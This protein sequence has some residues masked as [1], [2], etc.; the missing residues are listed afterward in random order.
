MEKRCKCADG[1]FD[2][3]PYPE[4]LKIVK[5]RGFKDESPTERIDCPHQIWIGSG[6]IPAYKFTRAEWETYQ[7]ESTLCLYKK[8][9][10]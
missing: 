5:E 9:N 1:N 6:G 3:C 2:N 4:V 7:R 8:G 10:D